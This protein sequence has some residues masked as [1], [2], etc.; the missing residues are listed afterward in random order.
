MRNLRVA[1]VVALA[2]S[3]PAAEA[4][5]LAAC[6]SVNGCLRKVGQTGS[7]TS[8]PAADTRG[9]S[10]EI[11]LDVES[12]HSVCPACKIVLV[13]ANSESFADLAA[14]V[15]AAVSLGA[16]EISNSY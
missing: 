4:G 9:W 3:A 2:A 15:E 13:E 6:T 12:V 16:M 14:S 7:A 5:T 10:V 8:L 1:A 11:S